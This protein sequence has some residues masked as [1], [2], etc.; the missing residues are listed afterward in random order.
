MDKTRTPD[1]FSTLYGCEAMRLHRVFSFKA[2]AVLI[3]A[4]VWS[5]ALI[6]QS[7]YDYWPLMPSIMLKF[8]DDEIQFIDTLNFNPGV[9][10]CN[11]VLSYSDQNGNLVAYGYGGLV[12]NSAGDT[13]HQIDDLLDGPCTAFSAITFLP[14]LSNTGQNDTLSYGFVYSLSSLGGAWEVHYKEFQVVNGKL[15]SSQR[16]AHGIV[17]SQEISG[18]QILPIRHANGRDWW[19]LV[20]E[21]I[22][23]DITPHIDRR[24]LRYLITP[25]TI[26]F[27]G[28]AAVIDSIRGGGE[29]TMNRTGD[30]MAMTMSDDIRMFD[31]DRCTGSLSNMTIVSDGYVDLGACSFSPD[32]TKLYAA[33]RKRSLYV[34]DLETPDYT[35]DTVFQ[36]A[37]IFGYETMN[38]E[39]GPDD[40]LYWGFE[41]HT[42]LGAVDP[43]RYLMRVE[44]PDADFDDLVFDTFAVYL[45]GFR[46]RTN[47]LPNFPNYELGRLVGSPCDTLFVD[48]TTTVSTT[49]PVPDWRITP[50]VSQT[51]FRVL[52]QQ[53]LRWE[54]FA[55]TG[56]RYA[57]GTAERIDATAWPQGI[58]IIQ[59][60]DA[61]KQKRIKVVRP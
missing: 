56:E 57:S 45:N 61:T 12:L 16:F 18:G 52:A 10:E 41:V 29:V 46:N 21:P 28:V 50:S 6:A 17:L 59:L 54:V 38:L 34:F 49:L 55:M 37:G 7:H 13:I 58:Y 31:F 3:L 23:P 51:N 14:I 33:N 48:T 60:S 11:H 32:D 9:D 24:W 5:H 22:V 40:R 44:N 4:L 15:D 30:R 26:T 35:K 53:P 43:T 42:G 39:L 36:G 25:D 47:A 27:D 1:L 19:L 2:A 20:F 8:Q